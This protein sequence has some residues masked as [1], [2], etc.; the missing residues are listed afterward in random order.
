MDK[1][2]DLAMSLCSNSEISAEVNPTVKMFDDVDVILFT[3]GSSGGT[4]GVEFARD[5]VLPSEGAATCY[6][7]I[8]LDFQTFDPT[9]VLSILQTMLCGGSRLVASMD[10]L[11]E[12]ISLGLSIDNIKIILHKVR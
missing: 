4:K 5:L 6:P 2:F 7:F 9:Y 8:T 12:D 10:K 1:D 3:S 11:F